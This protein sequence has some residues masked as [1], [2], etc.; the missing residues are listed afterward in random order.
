MESF[1]YLGAEIHS[2]GSSEPDVL[3]RIGVAKSCFNLLNRGIWRSSISFSTK[4]RL[5]LTYIQPVLLYG[6]ETW[7][8]TRA[9]E[10]KVDA[11]DY[12]VASSA[13]H[14]RTM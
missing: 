12:I 7:A 3:R 8:L 11:F 10:D 1:V 14:I 6:A 2:T 9:L 5:Y 4:V 13:F